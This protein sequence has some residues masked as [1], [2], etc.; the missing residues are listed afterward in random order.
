MT[1]PLM[2]DGT[3]EAQEVTDYAYRLFREMKG[4][5]AELPE[6]F[7]DTQNLT[8]E[9]HLLCNRGFTQLDL[10]CQLADRSR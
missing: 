3:R 7:V 8:P 2:P 4:E 10:L 5:E 6:A 9:A 1:V